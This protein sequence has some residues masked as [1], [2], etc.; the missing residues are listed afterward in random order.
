MLARVLLMCC[1]WCDVSVVCG[2]CFV[3]APEVSFGLACPSAS[4]CAL[5]ASFFSLRVV[6]DVYIDMVKLSPKIDS[7]DPS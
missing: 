4:R 3:L 2:D 6:V 1:R 5:R 7:P